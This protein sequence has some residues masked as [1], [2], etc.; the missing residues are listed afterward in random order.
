MASSL[1]ENGYWTNFT[2]DEDIEI[3]PEESIR[4]IRQQSIDLRNEGRY[5]QSWSEKLVNGRSVRFDKEGVFACEPDGSDYETA[6]DMLHYMSTIITTLPIVL[7]QCYNEILQQHNDDNKTAK[8]VPLHL[9]NQ[10]FN[11]KLAVT[12]P[13]GSTYPLHIDNTLGVTGAPDDDTRKLTCILYLNPDYVDGDGG[14]LRLMLL[15][16]NCLDMSPKGG[17]LL[18]FWSDC[19]PHEVLPNKPDSQSADFDRYALT[20][21]IPDTDPRNIQDSDS[22][23]EILR[24]DAFDGETWC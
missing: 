6:P 12:S 19:I 23:F 14:E 5:E 4:V 22:K 16:R 11:A 21:W 9:S 18:L 8:Q 2:T 1:K 15:D 10:T 17:R 7:N 20:I 24:G 3:I 13:G